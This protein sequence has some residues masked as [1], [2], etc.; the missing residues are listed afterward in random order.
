MN[1]TRNDKCIGDDRLQTGNVVWEVTETSEF[2]RILPHYIDQA[3]AG[4]RQVTYIRFS[5]QPVLAPRQG[6]E[7]CDIPLTHRFEQFTM[8]VYR[9][10]LDG[11]R[12]RFIIFDC[13]SDL[14]TAWATD[15]MMENFFMVITPVIRQI[16]A[17]AFYP[18]NRSWHSEKAIGCIR[19]HAETVIEVYS[20][21]KHIFIRPDKVEGESGTETGYLP[22]ILGEGGFA[23]IADGQEKARFSKAMNFALSRSDQ[24]NMDS[25]DRFFQKVRKD[26]EAGKDISKECEQIC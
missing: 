17:S 22:Q 13:L 15:L 7:I 1:M 3:L 5:R 26:F 2:S 18:L 14:Q 4:G 24:E 12:D 21:F 6:V 20:D 11:G 8:A 10:L 16:H 9:L 25:W 23:A 19:K